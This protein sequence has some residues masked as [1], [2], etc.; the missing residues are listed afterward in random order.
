M[1]VEDNATVSGINTGDQ[2]IN[3]IGD[4]TGTGTGTFSTTLANN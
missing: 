1:T 2:T 4:V 3:L